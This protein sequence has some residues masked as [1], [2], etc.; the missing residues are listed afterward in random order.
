[1]AMAES[2]RSL[3]DI[4]SRIDAIDAELLALVD[5]RA[6]LAA[7]VAAAKAAAGGPPSFGLRPG[8]E[9]QVIRGL[10]AKPRKAASAQLVVRLWREIMS[11]NLAAQGDYAINVWGGADQGRTLQAARAR[12]GA[13][14][15]LNQTAKPEDA[16]A[17]AR[18]LGGVA[19]CAL[20]PD[21]GWWGRLLAEPKVKIFAAL[22]DFSSDGP[23]SALAMADVEVEPTGDDVTFWVTD[24]PGKPQAIEEALGRDGVAGSFLMESGGLKLFLLSAYYQR[25]DARLAR[26]PGAL[27]GVIGA[28]PSPLDA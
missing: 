8:R 3:E 20:T 5:E 26:A 23:M 22:P 21:N 25:E 9:A 1:M 28:A 24:A 15:V 14:P 16:I 19:I 4:R 11:A 7:N 6:A 17:Q 27:S 13:A 18:K 10:L 2:V 12:F